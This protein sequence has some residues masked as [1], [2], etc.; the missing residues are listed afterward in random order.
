MLANHTSIGGLFGRTLK[1]YDRLRSRNA[2]LEQYRR[3]NM[4]SDGLGEF[5]N[6][7]ETVKTL[8]DEYTAC[9][10]PDYVSWGDQGEQDQHNVGHGSGGSSK[11]ET[12]SP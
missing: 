1:Q 4:F 2:F 6:A 12:S 9:Q 10:G 3:E 7:R 11:V 5:D 8:Q